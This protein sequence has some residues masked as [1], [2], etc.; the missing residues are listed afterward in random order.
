MPDFPVFD[1]SDTAS[2]VK[3]RLTFTVPDGSLR[4]FG[5]LTVQRL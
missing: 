4:C 1:P 5:L 3:I 2:G